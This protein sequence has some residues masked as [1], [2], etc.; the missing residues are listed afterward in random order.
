MNIGRAVQGRVIRY[1]SVSQLTKFD[2][3]EYGGCNL[4]WAGQYVFGWPKEEESAA[5]KGGVEGHAR[6]A[7]YLGTGE[8]VLGNVER[9]GLVH[10]PKPSPHLR[11]EWGFDD[12]PQ[13]VDEKGEPIRVHPPEDSLVQLAG[14]PFIGYIDVLD[15]TSAPGVVR[16][17]D[18]KFTGKLDKVRS[19]KEIA[20]GPQMTGYGVFA[21]NRYLGVEQVQ[22]DH[23]YYGTK[24]RKAVYRSHTE[25][26]EAVVRRWDSVFG[27]VARAMQD[28]ARVPESAYQT[29][30]KNEDSCNAYN[31]PCPFRVQG[32]CKATVRS[33][34]SRFTERQ[35][36]T[37]ASSPASLMDQLRAKQAA[38]K[39][40]AGA[41]ATPSPAPAKP[42]A[43]PKVSTP[44]PVSKPAAVPPLGG[45]KQFP[46]GVFTEDLVKDGQY[47][48]AR[49]ADGSVA[50]LQIGGKPPE[51]EPTPEPENEPL[52][53]EPEGEADGEE[54]AA[55]EPEPA[56]APAKPK[57]A[58]A[59]KEKP[60]VHFGDVVSISPAAPLATFLGGVIKG[61]A[62]DF[63]VLDIRCAPADSP[64]GYGKWKGV[65]AAKLL[66]SPPA[67]GAYT[68]A[69]TSELDSLAV[70]TLASSFTKGEYT[71]FVDCAPF[72]GGVIRAVR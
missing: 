11:L 10:L 59:P 9:P 51:P 2:P 67:P 49:H 1:L 72:P 50:K 5:Q 6:L 57:A 23:V 25:P 55:P 28:V 42:A 38:A 64:L 12:K 14:I 19:A 8:D 60:V 44:A 4:R 43:S 61:I 36:P 56:P 31:R 52:P 37:M 16:T 18:H 3:R 48:L 20:E 27:P 17:L 71:F 41:T 21:A 39:A 24:T 63:G 70:E 46:E 22:S 58:K 32:K 30:E 29:I 53:P 40:A 68:A 33:L 45:V 66:E 35:N 7:H 65:L 26:V 54:A 69:S 62:T 34:A 13:G 47:V 15:P